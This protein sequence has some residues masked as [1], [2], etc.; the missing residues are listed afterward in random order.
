MELEGMVGHRRGSTWPSA[1]RRETLSPPQ[2]RRSPCPELGVPR[3]LRLTTQEAPSLPAGKR[4]SSED[5]QETW[6]EGPCP[7]RSLPPDR[8]HR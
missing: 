7:G 6:W 5:G 3:C 4:S 8:A 2:V 1:L